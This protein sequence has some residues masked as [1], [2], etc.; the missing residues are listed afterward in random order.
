MSDFA[1]TIGG[2]AIPTPSSFEVLNPAD[3]TVV[4]VCPQGTVELI[5][6]A[7]AS[8]PRAPTWN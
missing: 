5:D 7:V 1:L 4:A 8:A 3:E 2:K 6:A